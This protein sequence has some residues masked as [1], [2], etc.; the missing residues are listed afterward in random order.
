MHFFLCHHHPIQDDINSKKLRH[1]AS[2]KQVLCVGVCKTND[3]D[4][5]IHTAS[6]FGQNENFISLLNSVFVQHT[7]RFIVNDAPDK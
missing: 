5:D 1:S 2:K 7:Q 4:M 3:D 6:S